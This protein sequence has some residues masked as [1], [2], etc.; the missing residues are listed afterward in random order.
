MAE[1]TTAQI[2]EY[3]KQV[4]SL[5]TSVYKQERTRDEALN[6]LMLRKVDKPDVTKPINQAETM[7]MPDMPTTRGRLEIFIGLGWFLLAIPVIVGILTGEMFLFQFLLFFI[8]FFAAPMLIAGYISRKRQRAANEEEYYYM[9][10]KYRENKKKCEEEYKNDMKIYRERVA[11]ANEV[12]EQ[13]SAIAKR[14]Y[15]K[16]RGEVASLEAP[17][18]KSKELLE[19]IYSVDIIFPKYRNMVAMCTMYEY[20]ASGRC[21]ELT[22]ANGAYNLYEAELRQNLI[23]NQLEAVNVNLD[24]VKQNQYVLYQGIVEANQALHEISTDVKSVVN[25]TYDIAMSNRI[26]AY[27]AQITAANAQAQTYLA[28]MD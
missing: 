27:C 7:P 18:R 24:Q 15:D 5:E 22:G 1:M 28:I 25:A 17:L 19:K 11:K 9:V 3:L 6:G 14:N 21:T 13:D 10:Q 23:I 16:A 12:F 20:F 2:T 8:G 26:T 4:S